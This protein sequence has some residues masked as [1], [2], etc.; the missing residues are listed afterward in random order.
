LDYFEVE[1][2][3]SNVPELLRGWTAEQL[4]GVGLSRVHVGRATIPVHREDGSEAQEVFLVV[5]TQR[6]AMPLTVAAVAYNLDSE[7]NRQTVFDEW[8]KHVGGGSAA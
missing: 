1:L 4:R 2:G 5:Q 8:W 3:S 6:K 7:V